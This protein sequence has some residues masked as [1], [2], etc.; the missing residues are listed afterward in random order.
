VARP[1]RLVVA[2][3]IYHA[4]ARGIAKNEI[5]SDDRDCRVFLH[6]LKQTVE[7]FGW[8]CL[9]YCLM[10]NHFHLLVR[11]PEPNLSRGMARL[12]GGYAQE[13]N[14]RHERIG[15]LFAGRFGAR[16]VQR[17]RHLLEVFRYIALNPVTA[18]LSDSP[19]SWHWSAHPALTG[20]R[21]APAWLAVDEARAW[22]ADPAVADGLA[23]Y[24][25]FVAEASHC[26]APT[27]GVV[28]GDND[29]RRRH[30]PDRRP[31]NE[32]AEQDWGDGRPELA[33]LLG[34]GGTGESI[35]IAYRTHGYTMQSIAAVLGRHVSTVSR[36]LRAYEGE[37]ARMQD[38][39]P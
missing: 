8:R 18:G 26:P 14:R 30:L 6:I 1:L 39:T 5:C 17:D 23:G 7:R 25:A 11:T 29:F 3:G 15:P 9:S 10:P 28:M 31:G 22:F 16:L 2:D 37:N 32:F 12:K 38:L 21:P 36:R 4:T 13:Y 24:R 19:S 27:P 20:E 34:D 33:A 35:G